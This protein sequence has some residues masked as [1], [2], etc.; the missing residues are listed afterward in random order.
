MR[1]VQPPPGPDADLDAVGA[2]LDQEPRALGGRDVAGDHL[3]VG[4]PL[5][6]L[7]HR[8]VHHHRV[9]VRDVD[10]EHVDAGAHQLARPLEIVA[11]R[12]DRRADHQPSLRVAGRERPAPLPDQILG[13]HQALSTP[14]VV[15][16]R[17][18]LDLALDHHPLALFRGGAAAMDD[19]P[20]ERRH[21]V[22]DR[23]RRRRR[24]SGDRAR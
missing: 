7:A 11:G 16:E 3:D 18:L 17:Q 19:E 5:A 2:A 22:G 15:D 20:I 14:V 21:A 4:E 12:A 24:R 1:V 23:R 10:D 8:P 6:E 9:A 13:R